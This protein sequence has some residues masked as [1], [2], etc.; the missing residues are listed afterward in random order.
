MNTLTQ[1]HAKLHTD[2]NPSSGSYGVPGAMLHAAVLFV[3]KI[4]LV[5]GPLRLHAFEFNNHESHL[6]VFVLALHQM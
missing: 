1:K 2:S 5:K 6:I 3:T 4:Y